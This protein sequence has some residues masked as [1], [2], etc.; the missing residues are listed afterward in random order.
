M[1]RTLIEFGVDNLDSHRSSK[2]KITNLVGLVTSLIALCYSFFFYFEL[3]QPE[4]MFMNMVFVVAYALVLLI[5]AFKHNKFAKV[6][7]FMTLMAHVYILSTQIFSPSANFHLYY[8]IIPTGIFVLFDE[9]DI[10]EKLFI[11]VASV[12]LFSCTV[13]H[14][15]DAFISLSKQAEELIFISAV[16]VIMIEIFVVMSWFSRSMHHYQTTLVAMA[17]KDGLTGIN[18][19]RTF[20]ANAQDMLSHSSRYRTKLSLVILDIDHFK[21][22][23]DSSGHLAGDYILKQVAKVLEANLRASDCLARYG[24]EEF[25]ILLPETNQEQ[26]RDVA[27]ILREKIETSDFSFKQESISVSMSL[28]VTE[29]LDADSDIDHMV[30]RADDALYKAKSSGRNQVVV[31]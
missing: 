17:T 8:L 21:K 1:L 31:G 19:R 28:G 16:T 6:W 24:G 18:N 25:I 11:M 7:F 29:K 3:A 22:I 15:G 14:E 20:I 27:E 5:N 4:L 2:V 9:E 30:K 23:N 13:N 10:K 12:V 26:A